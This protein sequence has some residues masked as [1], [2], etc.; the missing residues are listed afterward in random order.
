MPRFTTEDEERK[1]LASLKNDRKYIKDNRIFYQ[2]L[3]ILTVCFVLLS[4]NC[5]G[6]AKTW[7]CKCGY[8][9][10]VEMRYCGVCGRERGK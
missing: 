10:Y 4:V 5:Y 2:F 6:A 3:V 7:K 1:L 8:E 9:N